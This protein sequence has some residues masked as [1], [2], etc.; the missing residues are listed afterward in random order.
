LTA[1]RVEVELNQANQLANFDVRSIKT[2]FTGQITAAQTEDEV[3]A[4]AEGVRAQID[5]F[6]ATL[7]AELE[8]VLDLGRADEA[9]ASRVPEAEAYA[10]EI[11]D[12]L[13]TAFE[14][15]YGEAELQ[16]T[17]RTTD[18]IFKNLLE[19]YAGDF[20]RETTKDGVDE[21]KTRLAKNLNN[22]YAFRLNVLN[23]IANQ[24]NLDGLPRVEKLRDAFGREAERLGA[25]LEQAA[26]R[27]KAALDR[28]AA[29]QAKA[30]F[31]EAQARATA[32]GKE[33]SKLKALSVVYMG[34]L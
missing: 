10:D 12:R 11:R 16:A 30:V 6:E 33:V 8:R 7:N 28:E 13:R 26:D 27:R 34:D 31:D 1:A 18:I 23:D 29:A 19:A 17:S 22:N 3:I 5:E 4:V 9:L 20:E 2:S 14:D 24:Y 15:S 32:A 25:R 21:A